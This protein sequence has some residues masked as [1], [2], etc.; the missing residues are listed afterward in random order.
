MTLI[1]FFS[2]LASLKCGNICASYLKSLQGL[3]CL[4]QGFFVLVVLFKR[5][6]AVHVCNIY[7][8]VEC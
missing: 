7:A 6:V 1:Y 4:F 5:N 3:C 2:N 8:K